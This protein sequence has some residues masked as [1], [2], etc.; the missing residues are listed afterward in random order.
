M[1]GVEFPTPIKDIKRIEAQNNISI[2]VFGYDREE[3][4]YPLHL[5]K[6]INDERHVNLLFI[7]QGEK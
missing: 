1:D 5:T 7:S 2:N 4:V 3:K 6:D